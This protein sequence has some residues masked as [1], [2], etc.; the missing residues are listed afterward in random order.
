MLVKYV[1]N[2]LDIYNSVWVLDLVSI[3]SVDDKEATAATFP[4]TQ[5]LGSLALSCM[6]AARSTVVIIKALL[7]TLLTCRRAR[8]SS[9]SSTICLIA[10]E[11]SFDGGRFRKI[12]R[13][14]LPKIGF[15]AAEQAATRSCVA[16][17]PALR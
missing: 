3:K 17:S 10:S 9:N 14:A 11:R 16:M 5:H 7:I 13:I 1:K 12:F 4:R 15:P 6:A 8:I 2:Q